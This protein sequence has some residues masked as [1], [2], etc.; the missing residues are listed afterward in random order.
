M[1]LILLGML[2]ILIGMILLIFTRKAEGGALILI[3]PIPILIGNSRIIMRILFI[4]TLIFL[5]I[6]WLL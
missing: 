3:G 4:L 5:V 1:E 6:W 2:L